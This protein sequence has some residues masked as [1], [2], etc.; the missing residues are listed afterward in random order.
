MGFTP[1]GLEHTPDDKSLAGFGSLMPKADPKPSLI[2]RLIKAP[3]KLI[4]L[5]FRAAK[6]VLLLPVRVLRRA[7][8][9]QKS[10]R[11]DV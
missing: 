11:N 7:P 2:S 5:P 9:S 10:G 3:F 4:G 8:R 1:P 6:A